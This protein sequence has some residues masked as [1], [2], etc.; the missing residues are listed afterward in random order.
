MLAESQLDALSMQKTVIGGGAEALMTKDTFTN[1]E[2]I[3]EYRHMYT[4][5]E[6]K[7]LKL[8]NKIRASSKAYSKKSDLV[9][10]EGESVD[11]FINQ[12]QGYDEMLE[13]M[14]NVN[15]FDE[16]GKSNLLKFLQSSE[17]NEELEMI[18]SIEESERTKIVGLSESKRDNMIA[19]ATKSYQSG[20]S[21]SQANSKS[22]EDKVGMELQETFNQ[23]SGLEEGTDKSSGRTKGVRLPT[24]STNFETL[25]THRTFPKNDM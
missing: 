25:G 17:A 9:Q 12:I 5:E 19:E 1:I 15:R 20:Q 8:H 6:R 18:Q 24:Q 21:S 14:S 22:L 7:I 23:Q 10:K 16:E 13:N 2:S 4:Q 3:N 11:M